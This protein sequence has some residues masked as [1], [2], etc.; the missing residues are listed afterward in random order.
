MTDEENSQKFY[1]VH[2]VFDEKQHLF[3]IVHN[4]VENNLELYEYIEDVLDYLKDQR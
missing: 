1:I 2:L 4:F 3:E